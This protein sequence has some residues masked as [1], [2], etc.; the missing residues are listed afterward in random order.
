MEGMQTRFP[1]FSPRARQFL[2]DLKGNNRRDWFQPRKAEY[3]RYVR[4]PLIELGRELGLALAEHS[5]EYFFDARRSVYRIYRDVRFSK[6]K[7]PYK[8]HAAVVFA[9]EAM[10]RHEGASFYFHFSADEL[11][12]G[13]G[14]YRPT[15]AGLRRIRQRIAD[16]PEELRAILGDQRFQEHFGSMDGERLKR[17]PRGFS[18]KHPAADLLRHKQFLA[19]TA[20]PAQVIEGPAVAKLIDRHFE[21]LSPFLGYLN[22]ALQGP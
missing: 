19:G 15:S 14:L 2:R 11:L 13:G 21:A 1:G 12:V 5:P 4:E 20:F 18:T 3:L 7:D 6:N 16:A 17:A 9:H 22:E 10:G 8:T